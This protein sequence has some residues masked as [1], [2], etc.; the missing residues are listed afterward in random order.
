MVALSYEYPRLWQNR[1]AKLI[2]WTSLNPS[3]AEMFLSPLAME[4]IRDRPR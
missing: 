4:A 3:L 2:V 1:S